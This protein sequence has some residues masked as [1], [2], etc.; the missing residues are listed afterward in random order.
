MNTQ[1][2]LEKL[3]QDVKANNLAI[4]EKFQAVGQNPEAIY[5]IAQE[6]GLTDSF[7]AFEAEMLKQ[8][9]AVRGELSDEELLAIA[10]GMGPTET[11]GSCIGA[12]AALGF[13][14]SLI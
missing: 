14:G 5:A 11:V 13:L 8:T 2:F 1:E 10:G 3:E 12:A 6:A 9:E 7:E 4:V